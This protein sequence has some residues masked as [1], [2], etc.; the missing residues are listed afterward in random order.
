MANSV[1]Q[2]DASTQ[3]CTLAKP[4]AP[5]DVR[6]G[7]YV[8]PLYETYDFPSFFWC[9]DSTL[10]DRAETVPIR[11]RASESGLPLKVKAVCLPFVLVKHALHGVFSLDVRCQ[12]LVR[13]DRKYAETAWRD[14]KK[15]DPFRQL[16]KNRK[17]K[18][19]S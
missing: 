13:L 15:N 3:A 4:L 11:F 17:G 12:Q 2:S 8:S 16:K 7:D 10:E 14:L 19:K 9:C 18:K 6:I 5:E 1:S